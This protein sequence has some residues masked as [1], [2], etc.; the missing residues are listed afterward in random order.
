MEQTPS[1]VNMGQVVR[2]LFKER[3]T[4]ANVPLDL[5]GSIVSILE[6]PVVRLFVSIMLNAWLKQVRFASA[7]LNGKAA[8]I[9][10]F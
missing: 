2:K 3:S 8:L 5:V 4:H 9:A 6:H 1:G 10:L 7:H